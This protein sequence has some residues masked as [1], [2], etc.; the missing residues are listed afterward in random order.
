MKDSIEVL[1][2]EIRALPKVRNT[3]FSASFLNNAADVLER[4]GFGALQ[5][6]LQEKMQRRDLRLQ[7]EALLEVANLMRK[8]PEVYQRRAIGRTLFKTL[9]ALKS[10]K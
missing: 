10:G 9:N 7:A 8:H 6:F 4:D 3:R 2:E 5:I 1:I